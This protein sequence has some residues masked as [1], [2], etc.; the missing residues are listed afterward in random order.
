MRNVR[1]GWAILVVISMMVI[2]AC[3]STTTANKGTNTAGNAKASATGEPTGGDKELV[4]R[5]YDNPAGFD[6]A[7]IFRVENENIAFNVF[8]G[9]TTYDGETGELVP[10][11]AESWETS[12]NKIWT[13]HLRKGVQWQSGYG[14]FTAADVQY[15]YNRIMD[16]ATASTY[17]AE[18]ADVVKIE[19]P[20]DYTVVIELSKP[21]GNFLHVVANYHQG[22]I[23]K[24]EAIE[25]GGDQVKF[26]P[27]GTGPYYVEKI[28][29]NSEIVLARHED[30]YKGPAPIKR[31]TFPIIKMNPTLQLP[32]KMG[33]LM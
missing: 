6:P 16:P 3:G 20:D 23:V 11:L 5:F 24:Q 27:I 22:Q 18:F 19:T 33:R 12:D 31:I 2:S 1:M 29:V 28:D 14:E 4:V 8:G 30:Y 15:S 32:C 9:L 7:T 21:N 25:A 17:S 26:N 10:D 13:F